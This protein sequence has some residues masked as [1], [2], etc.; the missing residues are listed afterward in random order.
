MLSLYPY[1]EHGIVRSREALAR[2][3][4]SILLVAATGAGKTVCFSTITASVVAKG[5]RACIVAPR[6]EIIRQTYKKLVQ[7]ELNPYQIGVQLG[8]V[9]TQREIKDPDPWV[10]H[11]RQRPKSPIQL[12]TVSSFTRR[13]WV[14]RNEPPDLMVIDEAHQALAPSYLKMIQACR[15]KKPGMAV[16]GFTA[17]PMRADRK[18]MRLL[19]DEMIVMARP[20]E[21]AEWIN[22]ATGAPVLMR[23]RVFTVGSDQIV[24]TSKI[25]VKK[26]ADG[27]L[28]YDQAAL[29]E[30]SNKPELIG[31][32]V[33]HWKQRA[34]GRPT[35][36]FAV[37]I[38]HSKNIVQR[39]NAAGIQAEHLDGNMNAVDRDAI[40]ARFES[41]R[42]K[43]V[44]NC[45]VLVEGWD[46]LDSQTE[47]LTASGW[48]K[49]GQ[50]RVGDMV[51][52]L[53]V[54]TGKMELVPVQAV[55]S[56]QTR[57]GERMMTLKSQRFDIRTT[58]G[59]KFFVQSMRSNSWITMTGAQFFDNK[60]KIR[61]PISAQRRFRGLRLTS[62]EIRLIAWF[63]TDGGFEGGSFCIT[64]KNDYHYEIRALLNRIGV[65][66]REVIRTDMTG[67][68]G[69][70]K[71]VHVFRLRKYDDEHGHGWSR[72]KRF[73]D[74]NVSNDLNQ[75]SRQQFEVFWKE[76]L[77][78]DG[79]Q[80]NK[81]GWLWCST[82][83]QADAY[84]RMAA[85][86][87][88]GCTVLPR[89]TPHGTTVFRVSVQDKRFISYS[90]NDSRSARRS[91]D[92]SNG[93][94][95]WCVTNRNGTIVTRR[96]GRTAIL[97]NCPPTSACILARPTKS[98]A[99]GIQMMGRVLRYA[100]GKDTP[101]ILD[102]AGFCEE[103]GG[104]MFV[105]QYSLDVPPKRKHSG[106]M[107]K[108]CQNCMAVNDIGNSIC[109]SCGEPFPVY[110]PPDDMDESHDLLV[111]IPAD[112]PARKRVEEYD[113]MRIEF[114]EE[115]QR[116]YEAGLR[117][118]KRGY[119]D[120]LYRQRYGL[121]PPAG[122][123]KAQLTDLQIAAIE[124]HDEVR[125]LKQMG[126]TSFSNAE[127]DT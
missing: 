2:G 118:W 76:L 32:I 15:A 13:S 50:I 86:R 17:T 31:G 94:T 49:N 55:G 14:E 25:K 70:D 88:F 113:V 107:G 30:A 75:M 41:G 114:E 46:C 33:E 84:S 61:L 122:H 22:P 101:I 80:L 92:V 36:C 8:N 60:E 81:S 78:G 16:L 79:E 37:S 100:P 6:R 77:K 67:Y 29:N 85:V 5:K 89:I 109:E 48:K 106:K 42:T 12:G 116:R 34:L 98:E 59:H 26:Q 10:A 97:G 65:S 83:T 90:P 7:A 35:V 111:E 115:N 40:L 4:L 19:F 47:V 11:A 64:Q 53:N 54:D 43:V 57:P 96:G 58:E 119:L 68:G 18:P 93:E 27:S 102:H 24:D 45:N 125:L 124:L 95:V 117:P 120:E 110:T 20:H 44:A 9:G 87:G 108:T 74:K 112:H 126:L 71:P 38:A 3:I 82:S 62:D 123:K 63:M 51:E 103:Y 121:N 99:M 1:Q 21:L 28:D 72:Y 73:M 66:F 69:S 52:S 104:P 127:E 23:P 56:R 91:L 105:R 39:F